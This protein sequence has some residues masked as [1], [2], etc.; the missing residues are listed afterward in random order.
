MANHRTEWLTPVVV[1]V[2]V[3]VVGDNV[4]TVNDSYSESQKKKALVM[5]GH[6]FRNLICAKIWRKLHSSRCKIGS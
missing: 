5:H 3:V 4:E 1:V 2:V 6:G